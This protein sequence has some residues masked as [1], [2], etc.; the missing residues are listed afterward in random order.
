MY[1]AFK[2]V[3]FCF[4]KNKCTKK[5]IIIISKLLYPIVKNQY[6]SSFLLLFL[7]DVSYLYTEWIMFLSVFQGMTELNQCEPREI[8]VLGG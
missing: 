8:K 5:K 1:I 3:V 4:K 6:C 7:C 2:K